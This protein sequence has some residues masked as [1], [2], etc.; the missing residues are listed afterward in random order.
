MRKK[1]MEKDDLPYKP[2]ITPEILGVVLD[3][4]PIE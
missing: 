2:G 3:R 1:Y 4:G